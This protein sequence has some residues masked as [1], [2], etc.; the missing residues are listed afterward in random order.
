LFSRSV[1]AALIAEAKAEGVSLNQVCLAKLLS[2]L[3]AV[4]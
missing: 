1:H 2:Q 4:S 3:R